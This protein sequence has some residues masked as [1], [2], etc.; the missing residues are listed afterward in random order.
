V[1]QGYNNRS[2]VGADN[3]SYAPIHI[4]RKEARDM[5]ERKSTKYLS[6]AARQRNYELIKVRR[7]RL[8]AEWIAANGPCVRC[9]SSLDLEVDHIDPSQKETG[10][11]WAIS[12]V[13]RAAE[14]AKCQVLCKRCH[15]AKTISE[16]P[17]GGRSH[18]QNGYR[19]GCRCAACCTAKTTADMNYTAEI[20]RPRAL[21]RLLST[22][23]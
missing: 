4:Q 8:R 13:W 14:L 3:T 17:N 5:P 16:R 1:R 19:R 23:D 2:V 20:R 21:A 18:G 6:P 10:D 22:A 7:A 11:F 15:L 9:G 12:A